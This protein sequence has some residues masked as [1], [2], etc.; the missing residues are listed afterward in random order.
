MNEYDFTAEER[1][2][3]DLSFFMPYLIC[4]LILLA[5]FLLS[6]VLIRLT[7]F[8]TK[9][10][11]YADGTASIPSVAAY[12]ICRYGKNAVISYRYFPKFDYDGGYERVPLIV[13]MKTGIAVIEAY[14]V[15]GE[16]STS[17][18]VW[19]I[20][21][22]TRRGD[23]R[24]AEIPDPTLENEIHA[25]MLEALFKEARLRKRPRIIPITVM[26]T[27][28]LRFYG[29]APKELTSPVTLPRHLAAA[30][31]GKPLSKEERRAILDILARAARTER[32]IPTRNS[33]RRR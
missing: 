15:A 8:F 9:L 3:P 27:E 29:T 23:I 19:R 32:Q 17:G 20:S 21:R 11:F 12:M 10:R 5:M 24:T 14:H 31:K 30:D 4:A 13:V 33:H 7:F 26:P 1:S 2:F 18:D 22:R 28:R 16:V 25:E 6:R